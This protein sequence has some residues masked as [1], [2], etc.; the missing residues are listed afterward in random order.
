MARPKAGRSAGT[1]AETT[2]PSTTAETSPLRTMPLPLELDPLTVAQD[3]DYWAT[4]R[5]EKNLPRE[6]KA[7]LTKS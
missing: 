7:R 3:A 1:R 5:A 2:F 6:V 4:L